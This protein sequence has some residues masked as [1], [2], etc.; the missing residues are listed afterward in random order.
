MISYNY[1]TLIINN[2]SSI[3]S[4]FSVYVSY[5]NHPDI[6]LS[7]SSLALISLEFQCMD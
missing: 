5:V 1:Q 2:G 4:Y 3:S 7:R 6:C